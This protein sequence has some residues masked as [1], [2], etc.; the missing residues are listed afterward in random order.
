MF[1]LRNLVVIS[2]LVL[3]LAAFADDPKPA[4][5]AT[6]SAAATTT[7]AM[8]AKTDTMEKVN[9]NTADA[10]ALAKVKGIGKKKAQEIVDYRTKNGEFKSIDDLKNVKG[11]GMSEKWF[12]KIK[13]KVTV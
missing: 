4:D 8:P 3:S 13:D 9:I 6:T 2:G 1:K 11:K 7:S 10:D 5:Q 12:D